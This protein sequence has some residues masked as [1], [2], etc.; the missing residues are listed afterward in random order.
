MGDF[1]VEAAA[2][3]DATEV[4]G[5]SY[6]LADLDGRF[7]EIPAME[8]RAEGLGNITL[9]ATPTAIYT[10]EPDEAYYVPGCLI[11]KSSGTWAASENVTFTIE[12]Q[13]D[14]TNWDAIWT[15]TFN[16]AS[17]PANAGVAIPHEAN[18]AL[19]VG[20]PRGFWVLGGCGCRIMASQDVV[21][22]GWHEWDYQV[23]DGQR[24]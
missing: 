11:R 21:G 6:T 5:G 20:I 18:S 23:L 19:L 3:L 2:P 4:T 16:N 7:D 17:Q 12:V 15:C 14:G 13:I 1:G 22:G 24:A 9:S 10:Q 8:D